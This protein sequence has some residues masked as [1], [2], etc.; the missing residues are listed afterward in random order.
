MAVCRAS[1][2]DDYSIQAAASGNTS[3]LPASW[4]RSAKIAALEKRAI[5]NKAWLLVTTVAALSQPGD[6]FDAHLGG[7]QYQLKVL[8]D[9][10]IYAEGPHGQVHLHVTESGCVFINPEAGAAEG[11]KPQQALEEYFPKLE[12]ILKD[13]PFR[14]FKL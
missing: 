6:T 7:L 10:Q 1:I 12:A 3:S 2:E 5:F 8:H 14:N 13:F 9:G 4:Y 11:R